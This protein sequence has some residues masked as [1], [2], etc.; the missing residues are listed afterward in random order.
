MKFTIEL[1]M[2]YFVLGLISGVMFFVSAIALFNTL[3]G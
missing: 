2:Y 3:Q 1:A